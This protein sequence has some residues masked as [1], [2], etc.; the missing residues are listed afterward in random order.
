MAR[1]APVVNM[2]TAEPCR[3]RRGEA[4]TLEIDGGEL[5]IFGTE[6]DSTVF[7][8]PLSWITAGR[9][10]AVARPANLAL[11]DASGIRSGLRLRAIARMGP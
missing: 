2:C 9:R 7:P 3:S 5:V 10:L 4:S 11:L 1:F 8:A 6:A